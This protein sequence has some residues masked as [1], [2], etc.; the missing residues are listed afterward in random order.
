MADK[1]QK[2]PDTVHE[3]ML[4][5]LP[6]HR[7][8]QTMDRLAIPTRPGLTEAI[9]RLAIAHTHLELILRY[10]IKTLA[11][12]SVKD[13]LEATNGERISDLRKRIRKLFVEKKPPASEVA[14]LDV[15][16]GAAH[17]LSEKRNN[18]LHSA[19][20]ETQAG[21]A[22]VKGEDYHWS[23]APSKDEVN[24]FTDEI[25]ELVRRINNARTSGFLYE[26]TKRP[27]AGR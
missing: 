27:Q 22:V 15:L 11:E 21:A 9:G 18:I 8:M 4:S 6:N 12:L 1:N 20:S 25:L 17:R 5:A 19:W 13:A 2:K 14:K 16:L 10:T 26:A 3:L 23:P 24:E 7:A